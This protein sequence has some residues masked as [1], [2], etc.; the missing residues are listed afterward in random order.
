MNFNFYFLCFLSG[1]IG[2]FFNIFAVKIPAVKKAAKVGNAP[3]S[4]TAYFQ[5]ELAALL[6]SFL[7]VIAFLILLDEVVAYQPAILPYLKVAFF[8]VGFTGA[9]IVIALLGKAQDKINA[10]VD[11]KTDIADGKQILR[12]F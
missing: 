6:A 12:T 1:L 4:Y 3:F 5:D 8:F 2:I 7:T 10:I 9:S 11:V